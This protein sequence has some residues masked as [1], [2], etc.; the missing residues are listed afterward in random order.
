[1]D[2]FCLVGGTPYNVPTSQMKFTVGGEQAAICGVY[3]NGIPYRPDREQFRAALPYRW[4]QAFDREMSNGGFWFDKR[5]PKALI[6][7]SDVRGKYLETIYCMPIG[8]RP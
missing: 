3:E 1:M 6:S 8:V 2:F 7:L 5:R 4:R